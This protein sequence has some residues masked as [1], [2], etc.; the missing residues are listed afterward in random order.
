M[1]NRREFLLSLAASSVLAN[2]APER[3]P[4]IVFLMADDLG[5]GD[6]GCYG[7]KQITTPNIDRLASEGM[8][9]T[10]A[11]AGSTVCAPSRCSLMTGLHT[12]HSRVRGNASPEVPLQ[13]ED[14]TVAEVM[15]RA[16]Y[17]TAMFGKWGLG[18]A[19]TTGI[20]NLKGFDEFFGYHTQMQA[21][22][23]YP[24]QLW[25][26]QRESVIP[27]NFGVAHRKYSQD[28]FAQRALDFLERNQKN[29]FF[30][31]LPF[32]SPHAN[33][34][35][36]R[37]TGNGMEVPDLNGY[38]SKSWPAP[39]K[40]FAAMVSRLDSDVGRVLDKLRTLGLDQ[41]TLV[42]F[43]S[44]NGPHNEGGH[45]A[46]FFSSSG[47]L[48]GIKRDLYE[49]GIRVPFIARWPG[50]IQPNSTSEQ[51]IAFW[52]F[53]PTAAA[54]AGIQPPSGLDGVSFRSAL[55][56]KSLQE[57]P[58]LYWEFHEGGFNQAIRFGEWKAIRF[59]K[60]GP[61]ELYRVTQDIGERNNL[62]ASEPEKIEEATK[63]FAQARTENSR[64]PI[65]AGPAFSPD[66][67]RAPQY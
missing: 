60:D 34:E 9:F 4:N 39:E 15:Q 1:Q 25:D 10:Q 31:Y 67:K 30:L 13:Q 37:D 21:H 61:I 18:D 29:P 12:G 48:R 26:N 20:P 49:G 14:T 46:R 27:P 59:G 38:A 66:H 58:I 6:L 65:H 41:N 23:Y 57:R 53:L 44:D 56:G 62:A 36:G 5:Y 52:D 28:L 19:G 43:T 55:F 42:I 54:L 2:A 24:H 51:V 33:N 8:R 11:Y 3:K 7:Q 45:Q 32:T 35:L 17:R 47:P 40:G 64:F 22:T 50:Q 63:L 16:G